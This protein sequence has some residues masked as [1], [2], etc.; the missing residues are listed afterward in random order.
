MILKVIETNFTNKYDW[1]SK[2]KDNEGLDYFIMA[3]E[4]YKINRIKSPIDRQILDSLDKG[5]TLDC[6]CKDLSNMKVVIEIIK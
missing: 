2:L 6:I 3:N 5:Q 1:I 4:F